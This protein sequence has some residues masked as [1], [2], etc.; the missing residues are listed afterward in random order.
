VGES[1]GESARRAGQG[2][3]RF[4]HK[5]ETAPKPLDRFGKDYERKVRQLKKKQDERESMG[6]G[7]ED[8][9]GRSRPASAS[10]KGP[11]GKPGKKGIPS[12]KGSRYGGKPIGKVKSE[13]KSADQIRKSRE[14][15]EKKR[16]RNAR[17]SKRGKGR[18]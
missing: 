17:P 18:R 14:L 10:G 13:L 12:K 6:G 1:E 15:A 4:K 3:K 9:G 11:G 8:T 7:G 5:L 2:G 16:A